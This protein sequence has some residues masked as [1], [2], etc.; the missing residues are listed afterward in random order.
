MASEAEGKGHMTGSEGAEDLTEDLMEWLTGCRMKPGMRDKNWRTRLE[1]WIVERPERLTRLAVA[2]MREGLDA[3]FDPLWGYLP[4]SDWPAIARVAVETLIAHTAVSHRTL[5]IET[6]EYCGLQQPAA[7]HPYLTELFAFGNISHLGAELAFREATWDQVAFLEQS[8][9]SPAN[10]EER[11]RAVTC[12]METRLPEALSLVATLDQPSL[13]AQLTRIGFAQ[14][15]KGF[16]RL[17]PDEP[18]HMTFSSDYFQRIQRHAR[19]IHPTWSMRDDAAPIHRFGG[20][21]DVTC[22]ACG[23]RVSHLVTLDLVPPTIGVSGLERLEL[24]ACLSCI[25]LYR[26][27]L[28]YQHD[29]HG[30][31]SD[32]NDTGAPEQREWQVMPIEETSVGFASLGPRWRWQDFALSTFENQSRLGGHPSWIQPAEYPACHG[33]GG[34]MR[35]LLQLDG[36]FP[37]ANGQSSDYLWVAGDKGYIFWCDACKISTV[38]AQWT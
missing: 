25:G 31:P 1:D 36:S 34:V 18:L 2:C 28:V 7:L 17:Y 27:H 29:Q 19:H 3:H 8:L 26:E 35:F 37:L 20:W 6:L 22:G 14:A 9:R 30:T 38:I 12:L 5:V 10:N 4:T 21:G 13:L 33:C 24:V 15:E 11:E 32:L 16:V 23:G